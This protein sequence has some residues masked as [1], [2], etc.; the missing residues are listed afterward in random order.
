MQTGT[1]LLLDDPRFLVGL[2]EA[3]RRGLSFDLQ[4]I[5]ELLEKTAGVLAQ[6]PDTRVA[7]CHAGSPHDRSPAGLNDWAQR[8]CALS[9][10]PHVSC[11]LSGLGMFDHNWTPESIR[12]IVETCLEQFGPERVMFGSNFPVDKLYG[13]YASLMQVYHD[14]VPAEVHS[15]VFRETAARFYD[16]EV[17]RD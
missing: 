4:L 14:L 9:E 6:A 1:N 12:P 2:Q 7:L 11:K 10:L 17:P 15:A 5:P 8:L 16:L 3:G 13:D